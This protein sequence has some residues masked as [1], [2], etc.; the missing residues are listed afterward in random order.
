MRAKLLAAA[1]TAAV[2]ISGCGTVPTQGP[3]RSDNP[4]GLAPELGGVRIEAQSPREN[5]NQLA[6]VNGFLEAMSDS[7]AFKTARE[8]MTPAAAAA[9]KPETKISVYDQSSTK[10]VSIRPGGEIELKAPLIATIDD[11]GSWTPAPRGTLVSF[12]F[13]LTKVSGQFRVAVAPDGVFLGS[14]QL[15]PKL[16]PRWLYFFTPA[17]EML[18]PDP[19]YLPNNLSPGQAATQLVQ[20]LLKGPTA[21]LGNSVVSAAPPGTQVNVSVPVD[22]GVATVELSDAAASLAEDERKQLAAQI[23]WTL[24]PISTKLRITVDGAKLLEDGPD[25]LPFTDFGQYDPA[26][27]SGHLKELYGVRGGKIHH[28]VGLDGAQAIDAKPLDESLLWSY[29]AESFAVNLGTDFGAIVTRM[30]GKN[31]VAYAR[32]G[33]RDASDKIDTVR[34]DG[35]VLRPTFD[36]QGNLWILD[37]ADSDTPRL[38]MRAKDGK[39]TE[40]QTAFSGYTPEVLRMAP[41]G[42]RALMVMRKPN[43]E[44]FVQIGAIAA[45]EA[46]V[47]VLGQFRSLELP[48]TGVTDAAWN[49]QGILVVGKSGSAATRSPWQVNSDG[50]QPRLIPGANFDASSVASNPNIDTLPVVQDAQG[51]LHWQSKD[52]SW[53]GIGDEP[54]TPRIDPVYPG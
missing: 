42:V 17:R 8:Y 45:N 44:T 34:T 3:I 30:D 31:V 23:A 5:A 52:L 21:R 36:E 39:V 14:N 50:S 19:L 7:R 10:A 46:K 2:L 25:I 54:Q 49:Q 35:K 18:V 37:R 43:G 28:V 48:L 40:V 29:R 38:R 6:I 11:R 12:V 24:R 27:P 4:A 13:A 26:V 15:E 16:A 51:Q 1:V 41:D 33:A 22:L 32:L 47:P 53:R 20:E 9:W